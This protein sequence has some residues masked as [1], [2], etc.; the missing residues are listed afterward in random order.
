MVRPG[1]FLFIDTENS[2]YPYDRHDTF[3][4]LVRLLAPPVAEA[5]VTKLGLAINHVE[6]SFGRAVALHDYLSY[7]FLVGAAAILGLDV[8][9]KASPYA[10]MRE[11]LFALTGGHWLHDNVARHFEAERFLPTAVLL[12]KRANGA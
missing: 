4:P 11:K 9:D 2:L 6:P 7:D 12:Q 3:L 8:V 5:L 1:G 10:D